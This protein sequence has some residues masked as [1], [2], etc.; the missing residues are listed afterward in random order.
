MYLI[1]ILFCILKITLQN[2]YFRTNDLPYEIWNNQFQFMD[3]KNVDSNI[4]CGA[5]CEASKKSGQKCNA[6]RLNQ[7]HP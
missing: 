2:G 3:I 1:F 7:G 4:V 5:L 6:F